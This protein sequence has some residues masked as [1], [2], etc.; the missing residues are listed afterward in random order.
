MEEALEPITEVD[1]QRC[2]RLRIPKFEQLIAVIPGHVLWLTRA[3]RKDVLVEMCDTGP[4]DSGEHEFSIQG[5]AQGACEAT[6]ES[7][8]L[9]GFV[10]V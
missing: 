10:V 2:N 6:P 5:V 7:S 4:G 9:R 8:E 1:R 3:S